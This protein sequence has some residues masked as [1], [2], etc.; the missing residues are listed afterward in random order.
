MIVTK[1]RTYI[2]ECDSS[3][4]DADVAVLVGRL[5]KSYLGMSRRE[6]DDHYGALQ[7]AADESARCDECGELY[8][9]HE[10]CPDRRKAI[11]RVSVRL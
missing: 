1:A 6:R 3:G 8:E 2:A 9:H 5:G 11:R 7:A 4:A 10:D